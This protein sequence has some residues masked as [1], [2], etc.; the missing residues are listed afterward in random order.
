MGCL[1]QAF[2]VW[3]FGY[4]LWEHDWRI[5]FASALVALIWPLIHDEVMHADERKAE[6]QHHE[7]LDR[8]WDDDDDL[9]RSA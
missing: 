3:M 2:A 1:L 4:G 7:L 5:L 8:L 6:R 9:P